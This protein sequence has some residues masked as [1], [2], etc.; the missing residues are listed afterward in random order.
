M[1]LTGDRELYTRSWA[2][3]PSVLRL[4]AV[5]LVAFGASQARAA[6]L[7]DQY[8]T[9]T[10]TVYSGVGEADKSQTF[11]VGLAGTLSRVELL[12]RDGVQGNVLFDIRRTSSG[13]PIESD[14]DIL[15]T[16]VIPTSSL[17]A[18]GG[19][20]SVD[21]GSF[22]VSVSPDDV[23]AIVLRGDFTAVGQWLGAT[24][25][26][27]SRG[28]PYWRRADIGVATW[29]AYPD[30]SLHDLAFR[31]FVDVEGAPPDGTI[32]EPTAI[33]VWSALGTMGFVAAGKARWRAE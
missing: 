10:P 9:P 29:T 17:P 20:V 11:T 1:Y 30:E 16:A 33:L 26:G 31:V 8:F 15:A 28:Q 25:D 22:A 19:Y 18:D 2:L 3:A 5:A 32:P 12:L 13:L 7:L 14:A 21:I 27:Y 24:G 4:A 23:L 6:I